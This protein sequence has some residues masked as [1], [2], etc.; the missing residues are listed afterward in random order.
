MFVYYCFLKKKLISWV[1]KGRIF[2]AFI[3][4]WLAKYMHAVLN[5]NVVIIKN[6]FG[7]V[8][9]ER[10]RKTGKIQSMMEK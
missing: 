2:L 1:V 5:G 7:D 8:D 10:N 4:L 9:E 6:L 3:L